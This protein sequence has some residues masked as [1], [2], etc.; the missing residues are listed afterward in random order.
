[1]R[2]HAVAICPV[3]FH[4]FFAK[5]AREHEGYAFAVYSRMPSLAVCTKIKK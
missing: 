5:K 2:V 4:K 1:M 3:I